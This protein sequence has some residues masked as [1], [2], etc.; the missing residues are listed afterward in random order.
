[1]N[2]I[3][4]VLRALTGV[5][6]KIAMIL[7]GGSTIIRVLR[8]FL[9]IFCLSGA[10]FGQETGAGGAGVALH[11]PLERAVELALAQSLTLQRTAIGLQTSRLQAKNLWTQVFPGI[12]ISGEAAYASRSYS[13]P[14]FALSYGASLDLTL[15]LKPSLPGAM[16]AIDLAYRSQLLSY[17][18]ARNQLEIQVAQSFYQ[19]MQARENLENLEDLMNLALRQAEQNQTRFN[20]GAVSQVVFLRSRLAAEEARLRLSQAQA[21]YVS[22]MGTFLVSLGLDQYREVVL[23]GAVEIERIEA[24]PE[25]LIL[26]YLP[27]RPDIMS[28]RQEIE[29]L[30]LLRHTTALESRF[31]A[32]VTLSAGIGGSGPVTGNAAANTVDSPWST[33]MPLSGSVKIS[34]PLNPWLPGTTENLRIRTAQAEV[35]RA[36]LDLLEAE[37]LAKLSIRTLAADL[38][39]SWAAIEIA[40]LQ[41]Q[42]AE[43]AYELSEEGF[44]NGTIDSLSLADSRSDMAQ[45]RQDLLGVEYSYL[46]TI[47]KLEAELNIAWDE[48]RNIR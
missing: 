14:D 30:T 34:I 45:A 25:R 1:M 5:G 7:G 42:I 24:D 17:E 46:S 47:L 41:L 8:F 16:K 36:R 37:N 3:D 15:A 31:P 21:A 20:N 18:N 43:R 23:E 4:D 27:K 32:T 12:S 48:L 40:R 44:R 13:E 22:G 35:D 2:K 10:A 33:T 28:K 9:L 19:L 6:T 29:R 26:E 11:L 39:N 38:R